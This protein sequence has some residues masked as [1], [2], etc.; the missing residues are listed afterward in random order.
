MK[1]AGSLVAVLKAGE[2]DLDGVTLLQV[3]QH[4]VRHAREAPEPMAQPL[5]RR[6]GIGHEHPAKGAGLLL[7]A[8]GHSLPPWLCALRRRGGGNRTRKPACYA[9]RRQLRCSP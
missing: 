3:L 6:V 8:M 5:R 7:F 2:A 9:V 4:A 1:T